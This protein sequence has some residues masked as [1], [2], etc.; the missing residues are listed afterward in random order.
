MLKKSYKI[1]FT[2]IEL[3][4]VIAI[5]ALLMGI[6]V[7]GMR[8]ANKA[9]K[10]L[11]QK[12]RFHSIEVG[13]EL[14]QK[15]YGGNYPES[16]VVSNGGATCSIIGAQ[17]LAEALVGRDIQ[18]FDPQT[19]WCASSEETPGNDTDIYAS[20]DKG[21]LP[22]QIKASLAR[23]RGPYIRLRDV[24]VF[25]IGELYDDT[26]A[27]YP[28]QNGYLAPVLTDVYL[29][30]KV[31]LNAGTADE[32]VVKAGSPILYYKAN[33]TS[34]IFGDLT[35][36]DRSRWIYNYFD[37]MPLLD[38]GKINET[39]EPHRY[40]V[41][42]TNSAG[43][44]GQELFEEAITNPK[45]AP[46]PRPTDYKPYNPTNFILISAGWDGIFGTKDDITNFD[47]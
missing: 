11:K 13:L 32:E 29:R 41:G 8:A 24:G 46:R 3:L 10:D 34:K 38:L 16:S 14:F 39:T 22:G 12:S 27:V 17:H 45:I 43:V 36:V 5:I 42:Y 25:Q 2:L 40:A 47:Y 4:V 7:P 21:S 1:G 35:V 30:R 23:R 37:N 18:G 15:D 44:T 31:T 26:G 33:T 28:S 6:L 9:S 19:T 20:V